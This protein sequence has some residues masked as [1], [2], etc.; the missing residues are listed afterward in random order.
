MVASLTFRVNVCSGSGSS[1]SLVQ[2]R[3]RVYVHRGRSHIV[4]AAAFDYQARRRS[5]RNLRRESRVTETRF[6]PLAKCTCERRAPKRRPV[7]FYLL[8]QRNVTRRRREN[9]RASER[10]ARTFGKIYNNQARYLLFRTHAEGFTRRRECRPPRQRLA[11][12]LALDASARGSSNR[13]GRGERQ[14]L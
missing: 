13:L 12:F 8:F 14:K 11:L 1:L 5:P 3:S 6:S 9:T 7:A 10:A 2:R 4:A